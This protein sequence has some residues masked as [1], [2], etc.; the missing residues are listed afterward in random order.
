[1]NTGAVDARLAA[2]LMACPPANDFYML[3]LRLHYSTAVLHLHRTVM[4]IGEP[5]LLVSSP[6]LCSGAADSIVN[7]FN[8]MAQSGSI[9]RCYLTSLT[10][11]MAV[12]I[13]ITRE[14][15]LAIQQESILL[16]LQFQSQLESLFPIMKELA[17]Y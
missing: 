7:L 8:S 3:Q 13:H 9:R 15:H 12:A 1:M 6:K 10:A 17:L 16:A 11:V 4:Q 2:W 14:I 5:S